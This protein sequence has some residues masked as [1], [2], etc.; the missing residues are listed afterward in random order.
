MS[1]PA[2]ARVCALTLT[3]PLLALALAGCAREAAMGRPWVRSVTIHGAKKVKAGTIKDKIATTATS[4]IPLSPKKYLDHPFMIDTD[5]ERIEA[6]YRTNGLFS[7]GVVS[8]EVRNFRGWRDVVDVDFNVK[9][10]EY[11]RVGRVDV[12][13][14]EKLPEEDARRLKRA[15][16]V[17]AGD[18]FVHPD[19]LAIKE[20]LRQR[21]LRMGYAWATVEGAVNVNRDARSAEVAIAIVPGPQAVLGTVTVT[22]TV[23]TNPKLLAR[24]AGLRAGERFS[25]ER[26][27]E[28]QGRIY[29]LG[30][31]A[32]V[33]IDYDHD[34]QRP[35]V[36]NL[37]IT[38]SESTFHELRLGVG[39]GLEAIRTEVH[40]RGRFAVRNFL[41]GLRTLELGLEPGYAVLPAFSSPDIQ[42]HGPVLNVHGKLTQPDIFGAYSELRT[43]LDY[44]VNLDYAFQYH[45]PRTLLGVSR[46]LWANRI[47]LGLSHNFQTLDFFNSSIENSAKAQYLF[48]YVDPYLVGYFQEDAA[49]DLRDRQLDARKGFY[50]ALSAQ[51]GG[52]FAGGQFTF[53]KLV[54]DVR[55]YVPLGRH[56]VLAARLTFGQIWVQGDLASPITQRFYLGGPNSHRGF[57]YN[58]L[59]MQ[60]CTFQRIGQ[61]IA[62][63]MAPTVGA[64]D[65]ACDQAPPQGFET[66]RLPIGGDQMLLLQ[67]EA[68]FH[69]VRVFKYWLSG[70]T[71]FDAGDVAAPACTTGDC[72]APTYLPSLDLSKMHMAVGGGLRFQTPVGTLRADIGVR[73]NRLGDFEDTEDGARISNPDP[74][75]RV[76]F[77]ISIGEAF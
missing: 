53:E 17:K 7:A 70:A 19:Y 33:R 50:A 51:Q 4:W 23:K 38:V 40:L 25:Q 2:S 21:L 75:Q 12:I 66:V 56:V 49:L 18:V 11:T 37:T 52:L 9:E 28:A 65:T 63:G 5:K 14:L 34:P 41:G 67:A 1:S 6:L 22:G 24:H 44:D 46:S 62:P 58:R 47:T 30:M 59:S 60:V 16:K 55:G 73:L 57:N 27:D 31:F 77:H 32:A 36:A 42:R 48:G 43:S 20:T 54:P 10:G 74:G 69:I 26:L 15:V 8:A 64:S 72:G 68:R 3:T 71:F 13:G 35:E 76:A 29:N 61:P 45:G 39:L